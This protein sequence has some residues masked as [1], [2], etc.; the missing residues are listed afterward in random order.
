MGYEC[1]QGESI[2]FTCGSAL[3]GALTKQLEFM[4]LLLPRPEAPFLGWNIRN[5][6]RDIK[7]I[8][9]PV[10]RGTRSS[11]QHSCDLN[12]VVVVA[13]NF[14]VRGTHGLNLS[15]FRRTT[16]DMENDK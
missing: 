12:A 13:L 16:N 4:E 5:I 14:A 8:Q 11:I 1:P 3:L 10:W 7:K 9:S 6:Y 15:D 2:S